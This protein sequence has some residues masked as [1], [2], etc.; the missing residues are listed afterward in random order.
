MAPE[1][2][3][4]GRPRLPGLP[5]LFWPFVILGAGASPREHL[6]LFAEVAS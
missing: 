6:K 3:R 4:A 1:A 2:A 5:A